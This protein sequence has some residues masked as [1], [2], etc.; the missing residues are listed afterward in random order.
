MQGIFAIIERLEEVMELEIAMT[1][2]ADFDLVKR[3]RYT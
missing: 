3:V 2:D 1:G